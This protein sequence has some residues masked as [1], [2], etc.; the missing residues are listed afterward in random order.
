MMVDR[1]TLV[2]KENNIDLTEKL[3]WIV[4]KK[5]LQA[6]DKVKQ[7]QNGENTA[8]EDNHQIGT[9][10]SGALEDLKPDSK[11]KTNTRRKKSMDRPPN[12]AKI[13]EGL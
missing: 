3:D 13:Q 11:K 9:G 1:M 2:A 6:S 5:K 12:G 4:E 10:D 8:S 7:P